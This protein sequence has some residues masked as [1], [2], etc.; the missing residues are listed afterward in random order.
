[1][2]K[3]EFADHVL[4]RMSNAEIE[5]LEYFAWLLGIAGTLASGAPD[6]P[7]VFIHP[8]KGVHILRSANRALTPAKAK[9]ILR[10]YIKCDF[11]ARQHIWNA[12]AYARS[13][14]MAAARA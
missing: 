14:I 9:K 2:L 1:M 6:K 12:S 8:Y 3:E 11:D 7:I 13:R 5:S 10:H 4:L